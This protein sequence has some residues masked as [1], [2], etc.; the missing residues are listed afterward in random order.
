MTALLRAEFTKVRTLPATWIALLL[1][2]VAYT[3]LGVL[4]STDAV[5][6]AGADGTASIGRIGTLMLAPA[7]VFIGV[8]VFA[9]GSEYTG[10]QLRVSLLAAPRR[11]RLFAAKLAVSTAVSALAALVV[12]LPG[13]LVQ[14]PGAPGIGLP[15]LVSA[16]LLLGLIGHGVAVLTRTAVTPLAGL[17]VAA[18]LVAPTLRGAFPEVVRYLPH[19]AALSLTGLAEDPAAPGRLAALLVLAG[20]AVVSVGLAWA[21]FTRRDS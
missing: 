9:A 21:V 10:G 5:R 15:A 12:L 2:L 14:H 1:A 19:D 17:F 11:D 16:Y 4:A 7:Y 6:V 13:Y 3:V 18:V 20:W 8:A